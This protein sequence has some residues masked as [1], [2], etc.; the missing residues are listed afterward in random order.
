MFSSVKCYLYSKALAAIRLVVKRSLVQITPL[1]VSVSQSKGSFNAPPPPKKKIGGVPELLPFLVGWARYALSWGL[2]EFP[3][4]YHYLNTVWKFNKDGQ[5]KLK[6]HFSKVVVLWEVLMMRLS[7]QNRPKRH[8][9]GSC[10]TA[11][12]HPVRYYP[13]GSVWLIGIRLMVKRSLVQLPALQQFAKNTGHVVYLR[14]I[15]AIS[16]LLG[17]ALV[18]FIRVCFI[19]R[20]AH[21]VAQAAFFLF[22]HHFV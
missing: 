17:L 15:N 20:P 4:S 22:A 5:Y 13:S 12:K 10:L 11:W 18:H 6:L 16:S 21:H 19:A 7:S 9:Y 14:K 8:F 2:P 1:T 3:A